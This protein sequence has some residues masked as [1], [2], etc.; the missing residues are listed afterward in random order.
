MFGLL[1]STIGNHQSAILLAVY[2]SL[3][4]YFVALTMF[5]LGRRRVARGC[6]TAG[7][8]LL[9]V[10]VAAAFHW[11]HHWS[12]TAAY[13]HTAEQ[14]ATWTGWNWGG[15]LWLNYLVTVAWLADAA[16]W[17]LAGD[18]RYRNR[19]RWVSCV[20][21]GF[22]AFMWFNGAVVFAA[23]PRGLVALLGSSALLVIWQITKKRNRG[24]VRR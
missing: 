11:V 10:H 7:A 1:Q 16:W 17:W 13:E 18:D 14:T 21:H 20:L 8:L 3:A 23:R 24:S 5:V 12:H 9:L 15:G 6:W 4:T 19:P 2:A 22:L